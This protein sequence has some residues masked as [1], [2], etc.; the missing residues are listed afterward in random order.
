MPDRSSGT[1][2]FRSP[3]PGVVELSMV[4]DGKAY[5]LPVEHQALWNAVLDGTK[6]LRVWPLPIKDEA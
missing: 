5:L 2:K 3:E 1:F 6:F 4:I